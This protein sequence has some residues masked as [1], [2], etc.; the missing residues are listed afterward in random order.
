[1]RKC[2]SVFIKTLRSSWS[3]SSIGPA[4]FWLVKKNSVYNVHS[5]C[6]FRLAILYL[7]DRSLDYFAHKIWLGIIQTTSYFVRNRTY[8]H[9]FLR[10][11]FFSTKFLHT[12]LSVGGVSLLEN[13]ILEGDEQGNIPVNS[14]VFLSILFGLILFGAKLWINYRVNMLLSIQKVFARKKII[15]TN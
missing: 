7:T 11:Q 2:E 9:D 14:F 12:R 6:T 15:L 3:Y 5:C 8:V 10:V 4:T 1:M 13:W